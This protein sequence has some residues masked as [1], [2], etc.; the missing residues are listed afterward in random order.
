MSLQDENLT[1]PKLVPIQSPP[2]IN[3]ID[4]LLSLLPLFLAISGDADPNVKYAVPRKFVDFERMFNEAFMKR[5]NVAV[6]H[7]VWA[8]A[9]ELTF[10][11]VPDAY[12]IPISAIST[13]KK[14]L[15]S[16]TEASRQIGEGKCLLV[17][18]NARE[19][20]VSDAIARI[21]GAG[22]KI[23]EGEPFTDPL[24][25]VDLLKGFPC[26]MGF[27]NKYLQLAALMQP[28]STVIE[29]QK[30]DVISKAVLAAAGLGMKVHVFVEKDGVVDVDGIQKVIAAATQSK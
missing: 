17:P 21:R 13:M 24:V 23:V 7:E 22:M 3:A 29:I 12:Q 16:P 19:K 1:F 26:A 11:E 6:L 9:Q 10:V 14:H 25:T 27:S 2:D 28:G 4:S 20:V 30:P 15:D 18:H 5:F 8:V